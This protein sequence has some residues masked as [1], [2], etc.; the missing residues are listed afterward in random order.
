MCKSCFQK[1]KGSYIEDR[2]E[3]FSRLGKKN[4]ETEA[5][6]WFSKSFL[7]ME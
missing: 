1:L 5:I 3:E 2:L 6:S 4:L 7:K